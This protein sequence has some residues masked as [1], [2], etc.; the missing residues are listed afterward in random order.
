M[1]P[2]LRVSADE[3][4]RDSRTSVSR[5]A[6]DFLA[7]LDERRTVSA[8]SA[9][10]TAG[11]RPAPSR[12]RASAKAKSCAISRRSPSTCA[13]RRGAVSRTCSGP[14]TRSRALGDLYASVLNQERHGL[15][16]GTALR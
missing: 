3:F 2:P 11:V 8:T 9:T 6:A 16:L 10:D 4:Q 15:A 12:R 14:A 7:D 1:M 13:R 5:L